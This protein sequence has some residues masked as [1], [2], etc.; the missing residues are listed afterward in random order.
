M[1]R[2]RCRPRLHS[3][4]ERRRHHPSSD[5]ATAAGAPSSAKHSVLFF[6]SFVSFVVN[7]VPVTG[8]PILLLSAPVPAW[9]PLHICEHT[10][11]FATSRSPPFSTT[12][13]STAISNFGPFQI[14]FDASLIVAALGFIPAGVSATARPAIA[15]P[16]QAHLVLLSTQFSFSCLSCLS[17]LIPSLLPACESFC[18]PRVFPRGFRFTFANIRAHLQLPAHRHFPQLITPQPFP[19]LALFKLA[20]MLCL[21]FPPS[22][23]F[24]PAAVT[25]RAPVQPTTVFGRLRTLPPPATAKP[26]SGHV[27]KT[28]VISVSS[29]VSRSDSSPLATA[30]PAAA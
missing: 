24:S 3:C 28:S 11:S 9:F 2:Y 27:L 8:V 1:L 4:R 7:S 23:S 15:P 13:Y 18:S 6:V 14:G 20:S 22:V 30:L 17:W 16:P 19:I 5:C 10:R 29:V 25:S 12:D 26:S 21:S